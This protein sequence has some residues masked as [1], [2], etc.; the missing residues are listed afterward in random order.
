MYQLTV[1]PAAIKSIF[2][3]N[4]VVHSHFTRQAS[5]YHIS[6]TRTSLAHKTI[7]HEGP[8]LWNML[9]EQLK[10]SKSVFIFKRVFKTE[11]LLLMSVLQM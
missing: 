11:I 6:Y 2:L 8:M 9:K 5:N 4:S 3:L 10:A 1:L 7:K